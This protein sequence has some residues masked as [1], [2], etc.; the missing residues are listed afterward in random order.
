L[1]VLHFLKAN[2]ETNCLKNDAR[3]HEK[4]TSHAPNP[5]S[6]YYWKKQMNYKVNLQGS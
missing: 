1:I 5:T 3:A 6:F 2:Q 4:W